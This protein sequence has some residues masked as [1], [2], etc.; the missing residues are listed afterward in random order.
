LI[1]ENSTDHTVRINDVT[2]S[3]SARL[4]RVDGCSP[5]TGILYLCNI[6]VGRTS[7]NTLRQ[8]L[9]KGRFLAEPGS[10]LRGRPTVF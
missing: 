6:P 10:E 4:P 9:F 7:F 3:K 2:R 8:P 5:I 1:S